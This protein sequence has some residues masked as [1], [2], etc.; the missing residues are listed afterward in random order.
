MSEVRYVQTKNP[1]CPPQGHRSS[2]AQLFRVVQYV[3]TSVICD[4]DS[5]P[6]WDQAVAPSLTCSLSRT[7]VYS[8]NSSATGR[9]VWCLV[10]LPDYNVA[11][12]GGGAG[13]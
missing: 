3:E 10:L 2:E 5:R 4:T 7:A 6:V 13:Q 1:G 11:L 12:Y 8:T 9:H